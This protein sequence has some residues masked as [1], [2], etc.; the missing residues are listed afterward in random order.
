MSISSLQ[1]MTVLSLRETNY[2]DSQKTALS[3]VAGLL[4]HSLTGSLLAFSNP[5]TNSFKRLVPGYEA[6]IGATFEKAIQRSFDQNTGLSFK[7]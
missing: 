7:R 3:Y 5:S 6:P 1:K 4:D 2:T